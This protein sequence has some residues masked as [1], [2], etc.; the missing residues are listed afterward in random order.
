MVESSNTM[1]PTGKGPLQ[2]SCFENPVNRMKRQKDMT[3]KDKLPRSV[4][5]QY[6]TGEEYS[7]K[8]RKNEEKEQKRKCLAVDVSSDGSEF[9]CCKDQYCIRI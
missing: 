9:W 6:A 2:H 4:G 5:A 8:S 1:W 7:N 3:V